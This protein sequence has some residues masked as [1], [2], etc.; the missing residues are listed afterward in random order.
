MCGGFVVVDGG[1]GGLSGDVD[2][3]MGNCWCLLVVVG[4]CW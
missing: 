2:R 3:C 4:S 1:C